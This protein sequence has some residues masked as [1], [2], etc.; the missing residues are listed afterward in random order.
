MEQHMR[1]NFYSAKKMAMGVMNPY[2]KDMKANG[3]K[4]QNRGM[5]GC[6]FYQEVKYLKV[7]FIAINFMEA[8]H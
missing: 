3:N 5:E 7:N 1:D 2:L 4:T 8:E 6:K